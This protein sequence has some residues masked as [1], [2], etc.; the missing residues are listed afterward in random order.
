MSQKKMLVFMGRF[1]PCHIGHISVFNQALQQAEYLTILVGSSNQPCTPKNPWTFEER[2]QMILLSIPPEFHNRVIILPLRDKKYNNTAWAQQV[3]KAV[4]CACARTHIDPIA[5]VGVIGH[6]KDSTSFY[7]H[8]FPQWG[9][10]IEATAIEAV[11]A[12]DIRNTLLSKQSFRYIQGAVTPEVL[13]YLRDDVLDVLRRQ[14]GLVGY[15]VS[16]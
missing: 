2:A 4:N 7:L 9:K 1:S 3:Q 10:P 15:L 8:L 11:N 5:D 13:A 14:P 6:S 16:G 12:T